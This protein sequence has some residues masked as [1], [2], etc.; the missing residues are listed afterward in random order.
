MDD[1]RNSLIGK[2]VIFE[3]LNCFIAPL[4]IT[5]YQ[6]DVAALRRQMMRLFACKSSET[7]EADA[8]KSF[9]F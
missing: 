9:F 2:R 5:F 6:M 8:L 3:A 7:I 1:W 4:Y